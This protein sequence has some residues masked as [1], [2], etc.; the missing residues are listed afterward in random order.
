M[1]GD[2][3]KKLAAMAGD[4]NIVTAVHDLP[5]G[6]SFAA[7][8]QRQTTA[9]WEQA[10]PD[11]DGSGLTAWLQDRWSGVQRR[12]AAD[13]ARVVTGDTVERQPLR[14]NIEA[15]PASAIREAG[16]AMQRADERDEEAGPHHMGVLLTAV[17]ARRGPFVEQLERELSEALA[18][19]EDP[20]AHVQP[21]LR[22]KLRDLFREDCAAVIKEAGA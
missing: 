18:N 13:V 2:E 3:L 20:N 1:K 16:A 8:A 10:A 7:Y 9:Y 22:G 4:V 14:I 19:G 21:L 6:A 5:G 15:P 17:L 12:W 11:D